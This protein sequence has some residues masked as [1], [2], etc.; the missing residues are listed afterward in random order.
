M[1]PYTA[2]VGSIAPAFFESFDGVVVPALPAGWT[3]QPIAGTANNWI[4]DTI[5]PHTAPNR[6][7]TG[8]PPTI[9]DNAL[10]SPVIALPAGPSAMIFR[11]FYNT[12]FDGG[13]VY[14]GGVLEISING[15]GYTDIITAGGVFS[16]GGY[17]ATL[18]TGFGNPLS[19]RP[20]WGG[21]AGAFIQTSVTLP[22]ASAGQNVQLRWRIGT[23]NIFGAPGWAIDSLA[24]I[25][26]VCSAQAPVIVTHPASQ[27]VMS[28]GSTTL[29]VVAAGSDPLVHQWYRGLTGDTSTPVGTNSASYGTGPLVAAANY[30]VRVTNGAG[31]ANSNTAAIAIGPGSGVNMVQN[32]SF[33]SAATGWTVFEE[34]NIQWSVV[35]GV[36]EYWRQN[37]GTG[38]TQA[39]VFQNTGQPVA[40]GTPLQ[41]SF[42]IGN[43]SAVR[44]RM[45]VLI[46]DGDF[47][48]I[49]VCTFWLAPSTP[50]ALYTM[51][52]HTTK[53]W[54]N[55]AIYFY[56]ATKGQDGGN[57][58]LDDVI[59][60]AQPVLPANRTDCIDPTAP[61]PPGGG[62]GPDL[63]TNGHFQAGGLSG[64]TEFGSMTWQ[65]E[66]GIFEFIRPLPLPQPAGVI[67]Q[68]TGVPMAAGTIYTATF[69]LGNSS[70]VRK[71]VTVLIQESD[72]SD[73][74]ACTFWLAP[75]QP[76]GDYV[77][78][79]YTTKAWTNATLAIYNASVGPQTWTRIDNVTWRTTPGAAVF[80][81]QCGEPAVNPF[82]GG[83]GRTSATTAPSPVTPTGAASSDR[84]PRPATRAP[85][86]R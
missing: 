82:V 45:S 39:V 2:T 64:W 28:G 76:I 19:G 26:L 11:N 25:S 13:G 8:N 36:F 72:F 59:L 14:D 37:P 61:A 75:N 10:V 43:S 48:D 54:A 18:A 29:T 27:T 40:A 5:A 35:G 60:S 52:T 71:R 83:E 86:R 80:G 63:I 81:T 55:A 3:N 38:S 23:D 33:S 12:E 34:P 31:T 84:S 17:N 79:G 49:T 47:S 7:A 85:R 50:L 15:G 53:P 74:M 22:P 57:Y 58:L 77:M 42:R 73:L 30:W 32:G 44:K 51:N 46:I 69:Q 66:A 68:N 41:A 67:F 20:A 62:Q 56:A 9:S 65:V 1:L 4:T 24:I 16:A 21:N 6:A 78:Q 70:A